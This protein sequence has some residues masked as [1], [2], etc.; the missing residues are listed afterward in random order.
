LYHFLVKV[1][2]VKGRLFIA[3]YS[4]SREVSVLVGL[5]HGGVTA[6]LFQVYSDGTTA[7]E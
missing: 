7:G 6:K 1:G 3:I 4:Y 5:I 2:L